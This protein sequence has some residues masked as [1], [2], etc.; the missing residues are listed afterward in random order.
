LNGVLDDVCIGC[1]SEPLVIVEEVD[2]LVNGKTITADIGAIDVAY[3]AGCVNFGSSN[4]EN[5]SARQLVP[6]NRSGKA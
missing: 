2:G 3:H 4:R 5:V 1:R 6:K